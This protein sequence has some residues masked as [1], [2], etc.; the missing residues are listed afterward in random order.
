MWSWRCRRRKCRLAAGLGRR[1]QL[2]TG[3]LPPHSLQCWLRVGGELAVQ[4][5]AC[6][7]RLTVEF[8]KLFPFRLPG[9][10]PPALLWWNTAPGFAGLDVAFAGAGSGPAS[11][12]GG[13]PPGGFAVRRAKKSRM[14]PSALSKSSCTSMLART[15]PTNTAHGVSEQNLSG[16]LFSSCRHGRGRGSAPARE[17]LVAGCAVE[18][19]VQEHYGAVV[20]LVPDA[21]PDRLVQ[22][23]APAHATSAGTL[24]HA[25]WG[26][27]ASAHPR[28][29]TPAGS[30]TG[31]H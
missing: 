15:L 14:V 31:P 30:T 21:A 20:V 18:A 2:R 28:T 6:A 22:R 5:F 11:G 13:T 19:A 26:G 23:P 27:T 12:C 16:P 9:S 24:T 29:C 17:V 8:W 4:S 7:A 25:A 10:I 3:R 1:M